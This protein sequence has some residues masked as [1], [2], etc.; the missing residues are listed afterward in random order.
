MLYHLVIFISLIIYFLYIN[1]INKL[2]REKCCCS[3][4][5]NRTY[6]KYYTALLILINIFTLL[7]YSFFSD[8]LF[9]DL[10]FSYNSFCKLK[11]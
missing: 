2:E 1:Y 8:N 7:L 3:N 10:I 11:Y 4:N 6:I 9:T 5:P